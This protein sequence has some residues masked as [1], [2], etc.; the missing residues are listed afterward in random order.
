MMDFLDPKRKKAHLRRLFIGYGLMAIVIGIGTL[1]TLYVANG[2]DINRNNGELIQNGIVFVDSKPKGATVY[3]N[4]KAEQSRTDTRM[5][6]PAGT[7]TVRLEAEGYRSWERTFSLEGGQI[8]RLVYPFLI[9]NSLVINDLVQYDATPQLATQSPDRRWVLIQKPGQTYAFDL[10]DLNDIEKQPVAIAIP[11]SILTSPAAEASLEV[12]E[13][14]NDNRHLIF[15]RSFADT[16]EYVSFDRENPSEAININTALGVKPVELSLRNKRP[17]Q[18]YYLESLPG[19]LRSADIKARTISA[20]LL[21]EVEDYKSYDDDIILFATKLGAQTDKVD[22]KIFD[23]KQSYVLRSVNQSDTY[24]MDIARYDDEWYFIAGSAADNNVFIY[25]DP[26]RTI[27]QNDDQPLTVKAVLRL[28][29]P[30]FVAFSANTQ[31]VR[32]QSTNKILA[33]DLE[34]SQQYRFQLDE[35]IP[36]DQEIKWMDGHRLIYVVNQQS[37]VV[38]F[39][40]SNKQTLVTSRL[41]NSPF[42]DRDYDNVFTIEGSKTTNNKA[43]F[44]RTIIDN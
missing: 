31:F 30:Q 16:T 19:T 35:T 2:Y 22:I 4:D 40:G 41:S 29:K 1:I 9:P 38:D 36:A 11:P 8:Q 24:L 6:L 33:I 14:S 10:F 20:P 34:D 26:L 37:Y 18:F 44:T 17:D 32:V 23:S 27:K 25:T 42:F 7:Y 13:W 12:V 39:D 28:D 15:K 21:Q 5:V 43:A 3:L